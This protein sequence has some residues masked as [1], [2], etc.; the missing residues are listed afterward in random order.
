MNNGGKT[1]NMHLIDGVAS[2]RVKCSLENWSGVAYKIPRTDIDGCRDGG[3]L[4]QGWALFLLGE[5]EGGRR[6]VLSV[7]VSGETGCERNALALLRER[8]QDPSSGPWSDAV[9]FIPVGWPFFPA[10]TCCL[11]KRLLMFVSSTNGL[12]A[13]NFIPSTPPSHLDKEGREMEMFAAGVE[14]ILGV[15]GCNKPESSEALQSIAEEPTASKAS[16][17]DGTL[18]Y[19][20]TSR[21]DAVGRREGEHFVVLKGSRI[22]KEP[23]PSCDDGIKKL[24]EKHRG[25]TKKDATL[26]ENVLF[27]SPSGAAAFVLFINSNGWTCWKTS[28]G[29]TLSSFEGRKNT[30]TEES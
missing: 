24:R 26:R 30:P 5:L 14:T 8:S 22:A 11:R 7:E 6:R 10:K 27:K 29:E 9:L 3:S 16:V 15:F 17:K 28:S 1:I 20:K 19:I 21:A 12:P 25:K 23:M 13:K 18:F 4:S 2:G